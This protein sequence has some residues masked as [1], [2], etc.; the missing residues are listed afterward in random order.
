M[1]LKKRLYVNHSN[2][3]K[4]SRK[5]CDT[6]CGYIRNSFRHVMVT[7]FQRGLHLVLRFRRES[8]EDD[9]DF[10]S[11]PGTCFFCE[12]TVEAPIGIFFSYLR[13]AFFR[14][15]AAWLPARFHVNALVCEYTDQ[16]HPSS[17]LPARRSTFDPRGKVRWGLRRS[18][19]FGG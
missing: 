10:L 6:L 3:N 17:L 2:I 16:W 19:S 7:P 1:C 12:Y 11:P 9:R 13:G 14:A 4:Q 15:P 8:C 18:V 5:Y